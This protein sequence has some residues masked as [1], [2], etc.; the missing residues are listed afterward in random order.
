MKPRF[1][2]ALIILAGAFTGCSS[3][4]SA[5]KCDTL[6]PGAPPPTTQL[7]GPGAPKSHR[8]GVPVFQV[9]VKQSVTFRVDTSDRVTAVDLAVVRPGVQPGASGRDNLSTIYPDVI[10]TVR[11]VGSMPRVVLRYRPAH[12]GLFPLLER[13][14]Y[15]PP[16]GPCTGGGMGTAETTAAYIQVVS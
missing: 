14:E 10:Q 4:G 9:H 6:A 15:H 3:E 12:I 2:I 8:A 1:V 11:R 7:V 5:S 13:V 16:P